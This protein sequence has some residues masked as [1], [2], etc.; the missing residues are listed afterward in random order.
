MRLQALATVANPRLT[1]V[2]YCTLQKRTEKKDAVSV[3][4]YS[5]Y[6]YHTVENQS[7]TLPGQPCPEY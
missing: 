7:Q 4:E 3:Q 1:E 2:T 5:L 6:H